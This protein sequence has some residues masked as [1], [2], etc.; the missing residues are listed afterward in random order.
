MGHHSTGSDVM[1]IAF[2]FFF[3]ST[4]CVVISLKNDGGPLGIHVVPASDDNGRLVFCR[5]LVLSFFPTV[6]LGL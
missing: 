3:F 1:V 2:F 4:D 6:V 5:P